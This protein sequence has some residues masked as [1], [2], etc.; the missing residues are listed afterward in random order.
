MS[1]FWQGCLKFSDKI[2]K[3]LWWVSLGCKNLLNFSSLTM[4]LHNRH[5]T[6]LCMVGVAKFRQSFLK[7]VYLPFEIDFGLN[8]YFCR[9]INKCLHSRGCQYAWP[10]L[11]LLTWTQTCALYGF[12]GVVMLLKLEGPRLPK[13]FWT[14]FI[15]KSRGAQPYFYYGLS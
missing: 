3:I 2:W 10:C 7:L 5:H 1:K 9:R 6:R 11:I 14:P 8:N 15:W 12:R 13:L 4:K